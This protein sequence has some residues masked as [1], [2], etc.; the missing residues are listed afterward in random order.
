MIALPELEMDQEEGQNGV[1]EY[2]P[3]N[4]LSFLSA[5][6]SGKPSSLRGSV[7][8]PAL[9]LIKDD[10]K[11]SSPDNNVSEVHVT[12]QAN[13]LLDQ[14]YEESEQPNTSQVPSLQLAK[15]TTAPSKSGKSTTPIFSRWD[16]DILELEAEVQQLQE[17]VRKM[18][19]RL[20]QACLLYTSPSPRDQRGSRMP[21]SA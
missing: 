6:S 3:T 11:S 7:H 2:D 1:H 14:L 15:P 10:K 17:H 20:R 4:E 21:S 5:N 12:R 19:L 8:T 9:T 13:Q 18:E 16:H